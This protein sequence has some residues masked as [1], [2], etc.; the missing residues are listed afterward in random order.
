MRMDDSQPRRIVADLSK[1]RGPVGFRIIGAFKLLGAVLLF[2]AALGVYR[3]A[4]RDVGGTLEEIA[5]TYR[6]DPHNHVIHGIISWAS[7]IDRARLKAIGVGTFFY[8]TLYAAEGIGLV[9]QK[10]WGGYLTAVV[11]GALIPLEVWEVIHKPEPKRITVLVLN[12]A[13]LAYV[14]WK[15]VEERRA[16]KA[17]D[18][19][20]GST[21]SR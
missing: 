17:E 2:G 14:I 15:L 1:R 20:L 18:H 10:V 16:A 11:T 12:V 6:I 13:I 8:A 21:P 3:L 4:G 19:R 9:L 5:A 7:G